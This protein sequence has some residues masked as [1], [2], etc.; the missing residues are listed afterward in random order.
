MFILTLYYLSP[1]NM[2]FRTQCFT[3][4]L[5]YK[6]GYSRLKERH[7]LYFAF[8]QVRKAVKAAQRSMPSVYGVEVKGAL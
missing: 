1:V 5:H 3:S 6:G 8:R 4:S 2:L 7:L